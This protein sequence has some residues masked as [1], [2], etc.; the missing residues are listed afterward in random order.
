MSNS[1]FTRLERLAGGTE[2][3]ANRRAARPALETLEARDVPASSFLSLPE[4]ANA[5]AQPLYVPGTGAGA[6][7]LYVAQ[8]AN[9]DVSVAYE[10]D[11]SVNDN[12][13]GTNAIGWSGGHKFGDLTG[14]DK[15]EFRFKDA[16]GNVVLDF[17]LDYVS[18]S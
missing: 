5:T 10:Q 8:Q 12:T 2:T 14:S 16:N 1:F 6:G 15:A 7:T 4:F 11:L 13:Y 17:Y 18:A 9:G 3:G